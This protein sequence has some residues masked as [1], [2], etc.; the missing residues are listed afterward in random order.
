MLWS[1]YED[2]LLGLGVLVEGVLV[3]LQSGFQM[4]AVRFGLWRPYVHRELM[5][6]V[7]GSDAQVFI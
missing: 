2:P 3:G 4:C 5:L 7:W 1:P 6:M